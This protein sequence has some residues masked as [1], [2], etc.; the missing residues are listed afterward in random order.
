MEVF[1]EINNA[2]IMQRAMDD[3]RE[4]Q[5]IY[6]NGEGRKC[7]KDLCQID[8]SSPLHILRLGKKQSF[9]SLRISVY[10]VVHC[11]Y[12]LIP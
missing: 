2:E 5:E 4:L 8:S 12:Y 6:G 11:G 1:K 3:F 7:P 10:S 9:L